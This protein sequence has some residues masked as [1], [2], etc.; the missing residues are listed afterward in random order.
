MAKRAL[1]FC[2]LFFYLLNNMT[3]SESVLC[4]VPFFHCL[5]AY[6]DQEMRLLYSCDEKHMA[7]VIVLV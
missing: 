6:N 2:V 5:F 7:Y 4:L 3:D 1:D